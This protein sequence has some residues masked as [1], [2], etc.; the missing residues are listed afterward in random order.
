MDI[1][2]SLIELIDTYV[3]FTYLCVSVMF[4]FIVLSSVDGA[5]DL[6]SLH[7]S[8]SASSFQATTIPADDDDERT[9]AEG[10]GAANSL[11][12]GCEAGH[13]QAI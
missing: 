7:S 12:N 4:V 5:F 9:T 1:N 3:I 6:H 11:S 10:L 2:T 13:N 8:T